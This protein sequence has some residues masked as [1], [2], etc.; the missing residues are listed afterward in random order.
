MTCSRS[1]SCLGAKPVSAILFC[2]LPVLQ[3]WRSRPDPSS[4]LMTSAFHFALMTAGGFLLPD[5]PPALLGPK[6]STH[7]CYTRKPPAFSLSDACHYSS[8]SAIF[9]ITHPCL[10]LFWGQQ[11]LYRLQEGNIKIFIVSLGVIKPYIF[12]T[13]TRLGFTC[14]LLSCID[15]ILETQLLYVCPTD[16]WELYTHI[17]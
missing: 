7:L 2:P 3:L 6:M 5:S 10:A 17:E 12:T 15:Y 14:F 11:F 13:T 8:P 1:H 9:K 16:S 4:K